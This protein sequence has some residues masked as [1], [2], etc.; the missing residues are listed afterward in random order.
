MFASLCKRLVTKPQ[1]ITWFVFGKTLF[2]VKWRQDGLR[3]STFLLSKSSG[4]SANNTSLYSRCAFMVKHGKTAVDLDS[5]KQSFETCAW[6]QHCLLQFANVFVVFCSLIAWIL[7]YILRLF[8]L[9]N[10]IFSKSPRTR[11]PL[12]RVW[13]LTHPGALPRIFHKNKYHIIIIWS[14]LIY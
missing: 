2:F 14:I 7:C 10:Q 6:W 1:H 11:W 8:T 5:E 13:S 4:N 3:T 9:S 12:T